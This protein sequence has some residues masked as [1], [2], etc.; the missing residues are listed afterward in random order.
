MFTRNQLQILALMFG[1]PEKEFYLSELGRALGKPPGVFQRGINS[2]EKQGIVASRRYGNQRLFRVDPA[3][4]FSREIRK[5]VMKT[6][7]V[8]GLLREL[9]EEMRAIRFAVIYGSYARDSVRP[10]SDIDV[11]IVADD[12]GLEKALLT[13]LPRLETRIQREINYKLYTVAE[14]RRKRKK[15]DAFLD[16]VL[17]SRRILLKDTL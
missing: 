12:A 11:L 7:G 15:R 2:L 6:A 14:F 8:E 9:A 1:R 5:M 10:D 17:A 16:R 4:P 13:K 3:Y